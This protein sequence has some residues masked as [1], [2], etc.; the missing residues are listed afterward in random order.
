MRDRAAIRTARDAGGTIRGISRDQGA[1]RNAVR[2][3]LAP[4]ARDSYH[5][6]SMAEEYE[7]AVRDVLADYPRISV[8]QIAEIIEW[9]GSR[10]TLSDLVAQLRPAA[11]EREIEDL[12]RPA[13]GR[14][15]L[16]SITFGPIR[17]GHLTVGSL[18]AGSQDPV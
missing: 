2:R 10:R 6:A 17:I 14:I 13:L 5:R 11:L 16:G 8:T 18:N 7:P 12:N 3:A 15:R 4:D 9:P 1:S